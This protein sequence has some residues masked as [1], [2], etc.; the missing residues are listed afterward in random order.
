MFAEPRRLTDETAWQ[1]HIPFA[2]VCVELVAPRLLVE[3]GTAKGDSYSAFCQAIDVLG[4]PTR[5][6]AVDTWKGDPHSGPLRPSVLEDLRSH[7]DS[8]YARF[9]LLLQR[10]FDEALSEVDD[11]SIDLLHIDGYHVYEAVQHDF[12]SWLPKLS[13]R[14]VVLFHDVNVREGDFGVW[15]LWNEIAARYPSFAFVHGHGLGV[16][17]VGDQV[18]PELLAFLEQA[19]SD[20]GALAQLFACVGE[21]LVLRSIGSMQAAANEATVG[22]LKAGLEEARTELAA[23]GATVDHERT[24]RL[25]AEQRLRALEGTRTFRYTRRL[26]DLYRRVRSPW[27]PKERP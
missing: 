20:N 14:A 11:E 8:L 21:R 25:A 5:A 3:L 17:A 4:L 10:T 16:A 24:A 12:E 1:A 7:H 18:A 23:L 19:S 2:A 22:D 26:R 27:V 9:S 15:R 13:D 6:V